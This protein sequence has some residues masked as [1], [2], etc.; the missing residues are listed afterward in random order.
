MFFIKAAQFVSWVAIWPI[1]CESWDHAAI[2]TTGTTAQY[3]NR[4]ANVI[5]FSFVPLLFRQMRD[6]PLSA[7][8]GDGTF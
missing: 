2:A 3:K 6:I 8:R 7:A 1:K 4:F 5:S